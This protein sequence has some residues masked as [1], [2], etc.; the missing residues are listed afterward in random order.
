MYTNGERI[1]GILMVSALV[2]Y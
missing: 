1:G 2:A